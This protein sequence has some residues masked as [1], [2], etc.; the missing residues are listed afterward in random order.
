VKKFIK[1]LFKPIAVIFTRLFFDIDTIKP[2][3]KKVYWEESNAFK[4][5]SSYVI[6]NQINGD[7]VEF[8]VWKGNSFIEMYRQIKFNSE[9]FY[10]NNKKKNIHNLTNIFDQ[11]KFHA[12]DSFEG[13][14]DSSMDKPI[15]YFAGNY[16]A[17]EKLFLDNIRKNGVDLNRVTTTKGWFNESLDSRCAKEI[18]LSDISIAYIDCDLFESTVPILNFITPFIKTGTVLIFD[19]WFRNGGYKDNGVQGAVL[20]W[21][22]KNDDIVLQHYYSSDTRTATFI[23][24]KSSGKFKHDKI[25]CV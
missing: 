15:Q 22:D 20:N 24:R 4:W 17:D 7:Y 6:K 13:L 10:I 12:F 8:G 1:F 14:P 21:L 9:I 3:L 19:D 16:S 5:A 2:H 18:K 25:D 11:M 23:V